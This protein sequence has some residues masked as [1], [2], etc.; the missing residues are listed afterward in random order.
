[1]KFDVI[2]QQK[3]KE[4]KTNM[5]KWLEIRNRVLRNQESKRQILRE[6][7]IHW[8]T[9]E[10]ILEH[11]TP[12][13][14]QRK[15][16]PVKSKIG[17]YFDRIK[18]IIE[19]DKTM[20]K[21]QRHTAKRIWERLQ[22]E[23]F[24]GGYTIVKD[25][26]RE[27]KKTSREVFMP[28]KQSPGE[29]QVDFGQAVVKMD[30]IL[31]KVHFF[32]MCLPYS[33]SFFIKA[34]DRE[35]TETFWDGHV[36]AFKFFGGVPKRISYDNSKI[37]I[38]KIISSRAREV[39]TGFLQLVSHYLFKYHF[40]LVRRPNEKGVVE[41]LVKYCR[42]NFMVPVPQVRD[43][44]ELNHHFLLMCRDD[45]KR[46]VR[47]SDK[48]TKATLL[49]EE[50][51]SFYPLPF[52]PFDAC[53]KQPGKVNCELLVRFDDNDYSAPMEYA[54]C[55]VTVKGYTD[56]IEI[57]RFNEL[58]AIHQRCWEKQKQIFDPLHYLPLLERKPHS[59]AFARP[60]EQFDLP[61]C[62]DVLRRR[63]EKE[64]EENGIREYIRVLRLL[65]H[66]SLK[67][68]TGAVEKALRV[69]AVSKDAIE[70]FLPSGKPWS[71]TSFTLAGRKHLRLMQISNTN[72]NEYARLMGKPGGAA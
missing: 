13:G 47:G 69:R 12:P 30:G 23:G 31:R 18:E 9:L 48:K 45:L 2:V 50:S 28:L 29:A 14:Y 22:K 25:A 42:L 46:T 20:P 1:M 11:P 39:T 38:S 58:I 4:V 60:F 68:L 52:K 66:Y 34:Y 40:C 56:K 37:A 70:Q 8:K 51:F 53:R 57:W 19:T 26:V 6:T 5:E 61:G 33:D 21:K 54:F 32:V 63:Q 27:I 35:C 24:T 72:I 15:K 41:G 44:K 65:E 36:E 10:K 59:M 49:L 55:D 3:G 67:Q 71:N 16:L 64:I 62:F 17:P 43:F 7:G